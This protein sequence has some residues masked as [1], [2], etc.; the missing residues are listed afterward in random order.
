MGKT[1]IRRTFTLET[2]SAAMLRQILS[3]IFQE[4][5]EAYVDINSPQNIS[6]SY[7]TF[8]DVSL[9]CRRYKAKGVV[10]EARLTVN[11]SPAYV[12]VLAAIVEKYQE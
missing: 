4:L 3:F 5:M 9:G 2:D 8:E 1:N 10:Y 12:D 6:A 7:I 11:A